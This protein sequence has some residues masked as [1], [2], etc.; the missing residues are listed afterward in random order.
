MKKTKKV[1]LL[2]ALILVI[3]IVFIKD[4]FPIIDELSSVMQ[5]EFDVVLDE[6]TNKVSLEKDGVYQSIGF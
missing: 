3:N 2:S 4:K 6:K 1:I 5:N